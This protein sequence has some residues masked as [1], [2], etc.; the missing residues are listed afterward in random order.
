MFMYTHCP[1]HALRVVDNVVNS[2]IMFVGWNLGEELISQQHQE[3][4][5]VRQRVGMT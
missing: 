3:S 5:K 1:L 4:A 2:P